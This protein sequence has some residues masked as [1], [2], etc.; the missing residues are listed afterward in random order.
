M[1][2]TLTP[3][4]VY[5]LFNEIVS[6]AT[7]RTDLKAVDSTSFQTVGEIVL[8]TGTENIL[9]SVSTVL[10]RT[11]FSVR[12]YRAKLSS[13]AVSESRWGG[14]VRKIVTMYDEAE[15]T[16]D[17]NTDSNPAQLNDG[18]AVDMYKIRKPKVLQLN[19][20]GTKLLQKH[21]TRFRDQLSLAFSD[22]REFLAF[23]DSVMIEFFNEVELLNE[24]KSRLALISHIAGMVNMGV[25][26]VDLVSEYNTKYGTTYTRAE[27]LSSQLPAFMKFAAS[28][29]KIYSMRL[30]DMTTKYHANLDGYPK[31]MRHTPKERQK[32]IMYNPVYV[33]A[34]SEVYSSLF[35]PQYLEIGDF[36]GVNYWQSQD[37]PTQIKVKPNI[38]DTATGASKDGV[39]T[40]IPYCLGILFDEEALGVLPQ[41]DYASS[42][43]FN[44]AGGYWNMY[45]HWRFNVYSDYTE[46]AVVF[47][48]GDGGA[49]KSR[50]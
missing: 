16:E 18:D 31:I 45:M 37:E 14:Q 49:Q 24:T 48:L 27:L 9:N 35:N 42:T 8:R 26:V 46:N 20:Y 7:G 21:I 30:T 19:F 33:E 25:G 2:N 39:E 41:F 38:L 11:I 36:E 40:T 44:S 12:P 10:S 4:D 13:L 50:R 28:T 6:Q 47:V 3:V 23:I 17:W 32:M 43:P 15:K 22:E 5:A 29:I 34:E 1:A